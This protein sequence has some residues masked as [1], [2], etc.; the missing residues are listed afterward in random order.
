MI[1]IIFWLS[2]TAILYTFVGYPLVIYLLARWRPRKVAKKYITPRVS[3]IIAC[4]NEEK[5]IAARIDNL[6]ESRY[7]REL[8]EIIVVSDGSTD[9]TA[10]RARQCGREQVRVFE[11]A[12][13]RGK[14]TALNF[15]IE[16]A[17]GEI[18]VFTDARQSFE[19]GV[20]EELAANFADSGVGAVTGAYLMSDSKGS[21]VGEG[22]GFYWKYEELIRKSEA[23]V[24]SV[25]GATGAIYAVRRQLWQPLPPETLLDDVYTPMRIAL[26]GHRVVFEG[27]ALAHDVMAKSAGREFS[28]KVRTLMGNYQL[29]QLMPRLLLPTSGLLLQ[30]FSHKLMRL[31]APIFMLLLLATNLLLVIETGLSATVLFDQAILVGQLAFYLSVWFGWILSKRNRR[32][33]LF[34]VAYVFSVMNAAALVGLFYFLFSKRNV[35]VRSE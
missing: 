3:V 31:M 27:R 16:Q 18:L 12:G 13:R 7:P 5:N 22:V 19:A 20:I 29:C 15:G 23:L 14:P 9:A 24:G 11:Y 25:I 10:E 32:V 33:R 34:N 6:L 1:R 4:L 30:F 28:R 35:W 21:T 8:L 26:Q 17:S 2:L